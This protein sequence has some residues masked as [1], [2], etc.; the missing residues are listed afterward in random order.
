M[1]ESAIDNGN[2]SGHAESELSF[3]ALA[4]I[5]DAISACDELHMVLARLRRLGLLSPEENEAIGS[6][7]KTITETLGKKLPDNYR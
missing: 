1:M 4:E 5:Q 3:F 6:S 7:M 2:E